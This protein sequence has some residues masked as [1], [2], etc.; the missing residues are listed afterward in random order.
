MFPQRGVLNSHRA[1]CRRGGGP[2]F[3]GGNFFSSAHV[4]LLLA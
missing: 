3:P 4:A 1:N 2:S